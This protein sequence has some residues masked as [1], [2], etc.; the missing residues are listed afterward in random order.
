MANYTSSKASSSRSSN[1][2]AETF[3]F[4][5]SSALTAAKIP[6]YATITKAT[7][8]VWGDIDTASNKGKMSASFGSTS[9]CSSVDAGGSAGEVS[10]SASIASH[11]NSGNADAGKLKDSSTRL[12]I[13]LD[14][15]F[16]IAKFTH[17]ASWQLYIEWTVATRTVTWENYDGTVLE[18]DTGVPVGT[19]P[20]Y[21]GATPTRKGYTFSGWNPAV[22]AITWDTRYRAQF[23]E[24]KYK[25]AFNGNGNTGGSMSPMTNIGYDDVATLTANAFTKTGHTFAGWATSANGSVTYQDQHDVVMLTPTNGATVTLYAVWEVNNYTILIDFEHEQCDLETEEMIVF[26]SLQMVRQYG[27]KFTL[28]IL[29]AEGYKFVKWSDGNTDNPRSCTVTGDKTYIAICERIA[30][31]IKVNGKQVIGCYIVPSTKTVIFDV[32]TTPTVDAIP[33]NSYPLKKLHINGNRT[34]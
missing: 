3:T 14:G 8:T 13:T 16:M 5:I 6:A 12:S 27:Y 1:A 22:G 26:S 11:I 20:T 18:T 30:V 23:T 17:T 28:K 7:L 25:I 29:P 2:S 31:P 33:E 24:N 10:K 21:N 4:D 9:I 32:G 34:Y 15:P 19:T